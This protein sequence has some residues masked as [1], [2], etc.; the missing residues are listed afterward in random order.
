MLGCKWD[1]KYI[2]SD[3]VYFILTI[4]LMLGVVSIFDFNILGIC[5]NLFRFFT[6]LCSVFIITD[7]IISNKISGIFNKSNI[8]LLTFPIVWIAWGLYLTTTSSYV[9][10][11]EGIE[12]LLTLILGFLA[13]ASYVVIAYNK[14]LIS[15]YY[16]IKIAMIILMICALYEMI[17]GQH[18]HSSS[19]IDYNNSKKDIDIFLSHGTT[20]LFFNPNDFTAMLAI[21]IAFFA[22]NKFDCKFVKLFNYL[23]IFLF[24]IICARN[25]AWISL[26]AG[27]TSLVCFLIISK[28][29]IFDIVCVVGVYTLAKLNGSFLLNQMTYFFAHV[30][31]NKK[32][33][34]E[35]QVL[36]DCGM[37]TKKIGT[38]FLAQSENATSETGSMFLRLNT[39]KEGLVSIIKDSYGKGFGPKSFTSYMV[40]MNNDKI[41]K[42]PHCFWLE[43]TF[44]YGLLIGIGFILILVVN[45]LKLIKIFVKT[46][47]FFYAMV[48]AMD[49]SFVMACF[50]PSSFLGVPYMWIPI[51][52]TIGLAKNN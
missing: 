7:F 34:N 21:F 39:Y 8:I 9:N 49:V 18:L 3:I 47:D 26:L 30:S 22:P 46:N 40:E 13:V 1:S 20:T 32:L 17:T 23:S 24:I 25:D 10:F 28:A 6:P 36:L 19:L 50:A 12:E 29:K 52:L 37:G 44:N 5:M 4:S 48:I 14:R 41:M 35:A 27:V 42:N 38:E 43:I 15:V 16:A 33:E 11:N 45:L 2:I 51:G 31:G